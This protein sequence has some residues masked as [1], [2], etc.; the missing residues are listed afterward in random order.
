[1]N[2]KSLGSY[3]AYIQMYLDLVNEND[4]NIAF[5]SQRTAISDLFSSIDPQ[6]AEFSYAPGKWTIKEVIQH[7]IDAERIFCYRALSFARKESGMLPG[8]DEDQYAANANTYT[9]KWE[10][11][12]E[13]FFAVRLATEL[14]FKSFTPETLTNSG[15]ANNNVSSVISIGFLALGHLYHHMNTI[16]ERYLNTAA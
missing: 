11:L 1:M 6:K 14:L 12:K 2:N 9:R 4:L 7:C 3:P 16:R 8:F 13:E 10:D 5:Q 15:I